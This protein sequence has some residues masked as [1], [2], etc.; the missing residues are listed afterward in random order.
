MPRATLRTAS[1]RPWPLRTAG[2]G[3]SPSKG[4]SN[5]RSAV[6]RAVARIL[7]GEAARAPG[8]RLFS[9][10]RRREMPLS[11]VMLGLKG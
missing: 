7:H 2:G 8:P 9:D 5:P 3:T 11:S 1:R 10:A 4:W 6:T